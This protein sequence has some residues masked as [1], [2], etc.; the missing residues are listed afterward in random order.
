METNDNSQVKVLKEDV[1]I[2]KNDEDK[3]I[4]D[5]HYQFELSLDKIKEF[6][7]NIQTQIEVC[8]KELKKCEGE[9]L[10][11]AIDKIKEELD[12]EYEMKKDALQNFRKYQ[13]ETILKFKQRSEEERKALLEFCQE[14][15]FDKYKELMINKLM[16]E[17]E[18]DKEDYETQLK[19][20]TNQIQAYNDY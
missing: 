7:K 10:Q 5:K 18:R 15:V 14:G 12:K 16:K 17:K 13:Q 9:A 11:V 2:F 20:L 19:D 6:K 8:N 1:N 4:L 3:Y